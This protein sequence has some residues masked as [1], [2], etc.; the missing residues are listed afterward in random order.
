MYNLM[1]MPREMQL[2][3][4]MFMIFKI[5]TFGLVISSTAW[6]YDVNIY[7]AS[8]KNKSVVEIVDDCGL[9]HR[10][11]IETKKLSNNE[12]LDWADKLFDTGAYCT[13]NSVK[14]IDK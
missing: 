2:R 5:I 13:K 11:V 10:L 1:K 8:E 6:G 9:T 7:Q 12:V 14:T 3:I 4:I